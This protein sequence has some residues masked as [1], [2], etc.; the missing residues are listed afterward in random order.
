MAFLAGNRMKNTEITGS[1][2]FR[3]SLDQKYR[4]VDFRGLRSEV[5]DCI[6]N[7]GDDWWR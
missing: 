4:V 7:N 3:P 6:Q 1:R 2:L 5:T